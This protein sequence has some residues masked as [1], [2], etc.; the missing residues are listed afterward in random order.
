MGFAVVEAV[1]EQAGV[2]AAFLWLQQR[3]RGPVRLRAL[4]VWVP[5]PKELVHL[6]QPCFSCEG[7]VVHLPTWHPQQELWVPRSS[8]NPRHWLQRR[9]NLCSCE[10][11]PHPVLVSPTDSTMDG[12]GSTL[13]DVSEKSLTPEQV[14][15]DEDPPQE[16][17]YPIHTV[18]IRRHTN[19]H[20]ATE[21]RNNSKKI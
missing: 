16:E 1:D 13:E 20:T 21:V 14:P 17:A 18:R 5:G 7:S 15:V 9:P 19:N 8:L 3:G 10:Q 11:H 6:A 2:V 12:C 4:T